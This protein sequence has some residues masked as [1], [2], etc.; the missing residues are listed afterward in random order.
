MG[1][2]FG[3][4]LLG[5]SALVMGAIAIGAAGVAQAETGA[6]W[7]Y[8]NAKTELK[9]FGEGG[10]EAGAIF[11]FVNNTITELVEN[12]NFEI[13]CTGGQ[14]I[15][16]G[17]LIASGSIATSRVKFTGCIS[18]S[19]APTLTK[20]PACT[21]ND[22]TG[23]MGTIVTE[24]VTGSIQLHEGE[25]T[26][27]LKPAS[28]EVLK[29]ILFS[30]ECA[31]GEELLVKGGL[32][33]SDVGGKASFEE[34]KLTHTFTEVSKLQLIR[35]GLNKVVIDGSVVFSLASPHNSLRWAGKAA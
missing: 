4:K 13:L 25:P 7:G 24:K 27:S 17:K 14:L 19:R 9:C 15:E 22:P 29:K 32:V 21:P 12:L 28:G 23:G 18:L 5:L 10:L 34:H 26:V 35:V 30:E 11:T 6:C 33:F 20:L 31:V 8:L 2:R 1:A 16:G 3:L